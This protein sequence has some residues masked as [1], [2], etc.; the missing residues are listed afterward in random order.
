[1]SEFNVCDIFCWKGH[2][3]RTTVAAMSP[4][5][6]WVVSGDVSGAIRVWGAKGEHIQKNE[7]KLWDGTVKDASW[8]GDSTR[9]VAAGD[10]KQT[11][12][13]AIIWDTGSKTGEVAGHTKP[14][15]SISFRSQ[16]PFRVATGSEDF[17]V[18]T[19][20]GPPFKSA[21][22]H[23]THSNFVNVVRYSPDGEWLVSAGSDSKICLYIGKEGKF[24][25]EFA[26]PDG[27]TGSIWALAWSPD[28]TRF[29]TAGGDRKVRVWDRESASQACERL[30]GAGALEDQQI[31]VAWISATCV[32]STCL[33]G[34]LLVWDV[35]GDGAL[36]LA[37][38]VDGTQGPLECIASD[39]KT[40]TIA[41][42]GSDGTVGIL[43]PDK[44]PF[45]FKVGK[46]VKHVVGHSG[47]HTGPAEAVVFALDNCVRRVSLESGEALGEAVEVKELAV[48]C[49]WVDTAETMLFIATSKKSFHCIATAD[50][51]LAWSKPSAVERA[52]TAV[53]ALP[54]APGRVAV[55]LEK[56]EGNVGGVEINKFDI[57]LYSVADTS[58]ADGLSQQAVLEGHKGEVST[59]KFSPSGELMASGDANHKILIWTLGAGA[60]AALHSELGNHTARIASLDWLPGGT[61]LVSGSLDRHLFVWDIDGKDKRIKVEEAHKGGVSSVTACG[62][63]SFASVGLDG[64]LNVYNL[65]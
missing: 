4:N 56:P 43:P 32:I 22:T 61:R 60:D 49:G 10:G 5:S 37:S 36:T 46:T 52:P 23:Q 39:A 17:T 11:S 18:I 3:Q 54:G 19:H 16:R 64:F 7:Y 58:S 62:A 27:I 33:D 20:E 41:Y 15:N 29:V 14:I 40:G 8:S 30:V 26:K 28:S 38:T 63:G 9:I 57:L 12:A 55:A 50:S 6:Q 44:A 45:R 65:E 48:G 31:G 59:I 24:E 1:M 13:C 47:S 2:V 35:A 34:R 25:K 21:G 53:A 42:G 51:A